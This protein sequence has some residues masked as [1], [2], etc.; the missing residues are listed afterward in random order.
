VKI[1]QTTVIEIASLLTK[2]GNAHHQYEQTVLNGVYDRDWH[3]WYAEYAIECGLGNLLDRSLAVE[4]VSE[5]L[6]QTNEQ[7]KTENSDR[8][9]ADYT[10]QKIV[11]F[12]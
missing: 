3:I 11:E 1:T 7:Y 8:S 4:R 5:F 12:F 10:A 6:S 9:W 2:A